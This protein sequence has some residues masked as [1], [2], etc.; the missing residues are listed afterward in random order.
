MEKMLVTQGLNE[1]KLLD[2]RIFKKIANAK[3]IAIAK[4]S[5]KY[6]NG[7]SRET[8]KKNAQADYSSITDLVERRNRIKSAIVK[9]NA[10]TTVI[11]DGITMTVAEA[12][13]RKNNIEYLVSLLNTMTTQLDKCDNNLLKE[14]NKVAAQ[15]DKLLEAAYG[16]DSK[17]KITENM[18]DAIAKPYRDSN[19]YEFIDALDLRK[20]INDLSE[21]IDNFLSSVD[22][23]LQVSNSTTTIEF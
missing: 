21:H 5:E 9:S 20:K 12:I 8:F 1:L 13:D 7:V 22:T 6:I 10:N 2:D 4:K 11:V 3:F 19:E 17:E 23:V 14:N 15:I 18:Y 16:K